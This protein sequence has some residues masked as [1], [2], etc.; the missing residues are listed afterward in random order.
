MAKIVL[1]SWS[2]NVDDVVSWA[3]ISFITFSLAPLSLQFSLIL[4]VVDVDSVQIKVVP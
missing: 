3:L 4:H 2:Q 1:Q